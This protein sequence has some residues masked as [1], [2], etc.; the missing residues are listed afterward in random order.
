M[1]RYLNAH[2]LPGYL[3]RY[4]MLL[5]GCVLSKSILLI[6]KFPAV[7]V[8]EKLAVLWYAIAQGL[9]N[10]LTLSLKSSAA[11]MAYLGAS[12]GVRDARG[13]TD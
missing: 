12:L 11:Y 4:A 7:G 13:L 5:C 8:W 3:G 9:T 2:E 6:A 10:L 1:T